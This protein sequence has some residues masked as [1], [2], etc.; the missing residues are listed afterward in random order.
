MIAKS[1]KQKILQVIFALT[2]TILYLKMNYERGE[3]PLSRSP[4]TYS[5]VEQVFIYIVILPGMLWFVLIW[6]RWFYEQ[7]FSIRIRNIYSYDAF[8]AT[9]TAIVFVV[10]II[11]ALPIKI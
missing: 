5:L 6:N 2:E 3:I 9:G 7:T 10:M 8:Q 1:N 11:M 4:Y